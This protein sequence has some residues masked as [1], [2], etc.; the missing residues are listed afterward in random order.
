ME[1]IKCYC[2]YTCVFK[3][4]N[5]RYSECDIHYVVYLVSQT[6][7]EFRVFTQE[8]LLALDEYLNDHGLCWDLVLEDENEISNSIFEVLVSG[9]ENLDF[10]L[11]KSNIKKTSH[12]SS[13]LFE[14]YQSELVEIIIDE[15]NHWYIVN[16]FEMMHDYNFFPYE[17][18]ITFLTGLSNKGY[19]R[20]ILI[21]IEDD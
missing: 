8:E 7:S 9:V 2:F 17:V 3:D 20:A 1:D 18:Y 12:I 15:I 6:K 10:N 16:S 13:F 19:K 21:E 14:D 5:D 4:E 11:K